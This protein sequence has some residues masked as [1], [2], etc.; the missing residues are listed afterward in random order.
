[1]SIVAMWM[2]T[3]QPY[4]PSPNNPDSSFRLLLLALVPQQV[5][6]LKK[7]KKPNKK[8]TNPLNQTTLKTTNAT[9]KYTEPETILLYCLSMLTWKVILC[10]I[11]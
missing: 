3:N 10:G 4:L 9:F 6:E 1:M 2:D 7:K 11:M 8:P 5:T